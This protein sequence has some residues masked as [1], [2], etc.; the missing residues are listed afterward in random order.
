[1]RFCDPRLVPGAALAEVPSSAP[2]TAG[3]RAAPT[4]RAVANVGR[5]IR[6]LA[7]QPALEPP[8]H[9]EAFVKAKHA[10]TAASW[11]ASERSIM[12][13]TGHRSVLM[14]RRYIRDGSLFRENSA[15]KLGL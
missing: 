4:G 1:M 6:K 8:S 12:N 9:A 10:N 11:G 7:Q 3:T 5:I 13:Q 2:S 14:V 15:G